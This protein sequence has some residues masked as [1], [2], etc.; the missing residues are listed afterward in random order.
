MLSTVNKM[1][2]SGTLPVPFLRYRFGINWPQEEIQKLD[3]KTRKILTIHG[4]HYPKA[5]I[6]YMFPE[7]RMAED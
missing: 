4:Q 5:V 3:R 7:N 6:T 2:A 1:Q